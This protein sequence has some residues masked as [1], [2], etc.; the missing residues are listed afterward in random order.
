MDIGEQLIEDQAVRERLR[1][2]AREVHLLSGVL[3][4][5][6]VVVVMVLP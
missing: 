5:L 3:A 2:Q 4:F 1:V 6:L